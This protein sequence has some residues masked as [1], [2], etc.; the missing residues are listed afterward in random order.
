MELL[1]RQKREFLLR[2]EKPWKT[3][4]L[5]IIPNIIDSFIFGTFQIIDKFMATHFAIPH[6]RSKYPCLK[7][8]DKG[9][10]KENIIN[11]AMTYSDIVTFIFIP[12]VFLVSLGTVLNF[13]YFFGAQKD[14]TA[15][16]YNFNGITL[17]FCIGLVLSIVGFL[18]SE[19]IIKFQ[20]NSNKGNLFYEEIIIQ[21]AVFFLKITFIFFIF[22]IF[23][24]Y[25]IILL[26]G[27]GKVWFCNLVTIICFV[28]NFILDYLFIYSFDLGI[29]GSAYASSL[30]LLIGLIL[31]ILNLFFDQSSLLRIR[32][33]QNDISFKKIKRIV[34][35]G[36]PSF[37]QNF[38]IGFIAI[39][40]SKL[41]RLLPNSPD[42]INYYVLYSA[43]I[44]WLIIFNIIMTGV[45]R[46]GRIILSYN[47][48]A[49]KYKRFLE[50]LKKIFFLAFSLLFLF[51]LLTI[52]FGKYLLMTFG[53]SNQEYLTVGKLL[54][55][56]QFMSLPFLVFHYIFIIFFQSIKKH[57]LS[58]FCS[59]QKSLVFP[60][61]FNALGYFLALHYENA[62][63]FYIV[64]GLSDIILVFLLVPI[65]W[66]VY[67]A[68]KEKYSSFLFAKYYLL[69]N[70]KN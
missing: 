17:L 3:I 25:F 48:G 8:V 42:S 68:F 26:R 38:F 47:F 7:N 56:L 9:F 31:I 20:L 27:E 58:I 6:L 44:P 45:T 32:W 5:I 28:L 57:K 54:I 62:Y 46:G 1:K 49:K 4:F 34:F 35:F 67:S 15:R 10:L 69:G 22:F 37:F 12:F 70:K 41:N 33:K 63:Y 59:T 64:S 65:G 39:I 2:H 29:A 36:L 23:F 16:S 24:I 53:I 40:I 51:F 13:S 55:I 52:F 43:I 18:L 60:A 14:K 50:F 19:I 66:K 30:S 61:L 11:V 21:E